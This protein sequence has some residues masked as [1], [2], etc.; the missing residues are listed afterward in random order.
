MS[1]ILRKMK[2]TEFSSVYQIMEASFPAA[3]FRNYE[4]ASKLINFSNYEVWVIEE[5]KKIQAFIAV[6]KLRNCNFVEH[7]AVNSFIRGGGLGTKTMKTY[8]EQTELPVIIEVEAI[9]TEIA[10]R[11][12]DFYKRL[13]FILSDVKY[14]Q[15]PLQKASEDVLLQLMYYPASIAKENLLA[16]K[17]DI[18][19]TVYSHL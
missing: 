2:T 9:D 14:I 1:N 11:R 7:F 16:M 5:E 4:E 10:K 6:W 18:F 12:I 15:P 3:E 19:Q 8:L 13:G 17:Q